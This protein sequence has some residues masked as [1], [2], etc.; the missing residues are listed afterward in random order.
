MIDLRSDVK[1]VPTPEMLQAMIAA[2]VGDDVAGE[3]PAVN[4]LQAHC[5]EL[6]GTEAALFVTAGTQGNLVSVYS[7]IRPGEELICHEKA[8]IYHYERSGMAAVCGALVRPIPGALG[9]LDLD[10]LADTLSAG[11]LHRQRTGLVCLENTHNNCGGTA[12]T[13][14]HTQAVADLAHDYGVP[15]HIDGAR[16]FNAA[17]ALGVDVADLVAPADTITFC[18]SKGLG[19]PVGAMVCGS[20][21]VIQRTREARKLFGGGMRQAGILAAAAMWA[22]EHNVPKLADDHRRIRQ[23]AAT[24]AALPGIEVDLDSVQTNMVYFRV[25]REDI[26]APRLCERLADYDIKAYARDETLIRLVTHVQV[27]DA[28]ADAVCGALREILA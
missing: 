23:I 8:H 11:D 3:D 13:V 10:R 15:V 6:L 22:L 19:A 14:E 20:A 7:L 4:A 21:E 27:T 25:E 9:T 26:G 18:F 12:L 5:A 24:L 17:V 2:E 16:I 1:T 28:D